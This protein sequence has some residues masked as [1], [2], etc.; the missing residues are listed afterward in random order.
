MKNKKDL[1][2]DKIISVAETT[3]K[4]EWLKWLKSEKI[5]V[6]HRKDED[7]MEDFAKSGTTM[8]EI[9]QHLRFDAYLDE[10][11]SAYYIFYFVNE[12]FEAVESF[13]EI[14]C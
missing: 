7:L 10:N 3:S 11:V 1:D 2:L 5:K 9:E 14:S 4:T 12:K 8:F 6:R 13:E